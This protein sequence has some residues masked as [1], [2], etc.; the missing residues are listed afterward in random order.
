MF[1]IVYVSQKVCDEMRP[2]EHPELSAEKRNMKRLKSE[3]KMKPRQFLIQH[4][5]LKVTSFRF[6]RMFHNYSAALIL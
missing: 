5:E 4:V 1:L 3:V 6:C 2:V